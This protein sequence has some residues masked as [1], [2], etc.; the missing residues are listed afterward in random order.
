MAR[1]FIAAVHFPDGDHTFFVVLDAPNKEELVTLGTDTQPI[2]QSLRLP[3][4]YVDN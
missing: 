3:A 4:T 1:L 2:I